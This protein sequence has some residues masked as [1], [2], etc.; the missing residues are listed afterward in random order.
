M[1]NNV[2]STSSEKNMIAPQ[3]A[4]IS[5]IVALAKIGRPYG[6]SG[7]MHVFPYSNDAATLRRAKSIVV[8]EK[9]YSVKSI[10]AHG[11]ALVMMLDDVVTPE[12][13]QTFTNA[14]IL[15]SR[16]AFAP[17]PAGEYYWIDLI[18]LDCTNGDRSFGKIVEVFE[19]GAHP[20]LRVRRDENVGDDELIP[21]VDAIVRSVDIDTK[22]VDVDWGGL[23]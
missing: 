15:V 20:I 6:L 21:F 19:A 9:Q 12:L 1:K 23:D 2:D 10:R 13:A 5:E 7:A 11:D 17:L 14:E 18:G 22:R 8:R 16:E 4:A 3:K